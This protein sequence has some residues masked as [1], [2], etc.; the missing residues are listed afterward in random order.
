MV[1]YPSKEAKRVYAAA[2]RFV[3][4]ALKDDDSL[5]TPGR[6]VWS[7]ATLDDLHE[8]FVEHPDTSSDKFEVK[9]ERQLRGAPDLTIQLAAELTY[10]HLLITRSMGGDRKRELLGT[11]LSWMS[12]PVQIPAPLDEALDDGFVSTGMAFLTR[13]PNQLWFLIAF[14]R[15][16]KSLPAQERESCLDDPWKFKD[17][18]LAAAQK[19]SAS[20][21]DALLHLVFPDTFEAI[22]LREAKS[23]IAE[24]FKEYVR[25]STTD[26]DRQLLEIR[27]GLT[28]EYGADFQFWQPELATRWQKDTSHWGRFVQWARR[29]YDPDKIDALERNYKLECAAQ[30]RAAI[31]AVLAGEANWP[32]KMR[33]AFGGKNN[34]TS[35]YMHARFLGWCEQETAAALN[36]LQLLFSE[37]RHLAERIRA[38]SRALPKE[39]VSGQ[40]SRV[41]LISYLLMGV[42]PTEYPPYQATPYKKAMKL[43]GFPGSSPTSPEETVYAWAL[44]FLDDFIVQAAALGLELRDRLDAQSLVWILTRMYRIDELSPEER[45]AFLEFMQEEDPAD[46]TEP[47]VAE[48]EGQETEEEP[49]DTLEALAARLFMP[50]SCLEEMRRLLLAKK[51]IVFYGP[52]G[53]GK[54]YVALQLAEHLARSSNAVTVVQFHPSYAYEDFVE[55]YRPHMFDTGP[56]FQLRDGPLKQIAEQASAAPADLHVLVIDEINRGNIAKIFGE[57]YFLLEYRRHEIKLQY[58]GKLFSLPDNLLVIGTMNTA[59][60]SIALVDLALRRRFFF[61]PFFPDRPPVHGVLERWLSRHKPELAWVARVVDRLNKRLDDRDVAVGPSY[62][63]RADLDE[64]WVRLIWQHSIL[65]YVAEQLD[66]QP[67]RLEEFDLEALRRAGDGVRDGGGDG[68][69]VGDAGD[70]TEASEQGADAPAE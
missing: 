41:N 70:G 22:V 9:F 6:A 7:A 50:S 8:R 68:T 63:M 19:G 69:D 30:V 21:E 5:F 45:A 67:D 35:H 39:V 34:I 28:P 51:Q 27:Q 62:F 31:D 46:A 54:T 55:G 33:R 44:Q 32:E 43:V 13:R 38:F 40:G 42:D 18:V 24:H 26:L 57:L 23:R 59:D 47:V 25:S 53:T 15:R 48:P 2:Q 16:W 58:S 65:P 37:G 61:Y 60:R 1:R 56:G 36:A 4:A 3:A 11:I 49:H 14:M 20:Q 52:P 66:G 17:V 29:F 12:D 64:E 10:V